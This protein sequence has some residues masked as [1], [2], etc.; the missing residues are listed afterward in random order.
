MCP[1]P[2]APMRAWHML[3]DRGRTMRH[4]AAQMRGHAL[5][6]E[7]NLDGPGGDARLDFLTDEAV[8]N[9]VIV[10]GD[11]DMI[12]EVDAAALPFRVLVGFFRQRQQ[13]RTIEFIEQLAPAASPAPQRAVVEIDEKAADRSVES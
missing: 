5:A 8:R 13:G 9:A 3:G 12:I 4:G 6:A 10:L 7:E 11:L 1:V 2:I